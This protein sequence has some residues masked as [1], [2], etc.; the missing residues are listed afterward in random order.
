MHTLLSANQSARTIF[1][2][3]LLFPSPQDEEGICTGKYFCENGLVILL[4]KAASTFLR[5]QLFEC[6]NE[7][8]KVLIP[9]LEARREYKKLIHVHQ[10]LSEAFTMI[11]K[12]VRRKVR[13][14]IICL[15]VIRDLEILGQGRLRLRDLT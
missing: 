6:V 15:Q 12:T 5:A 14:N 8:Y 2:T 3:P 10:R 13:L 9:I 4:E 1:V 11:I 7:V